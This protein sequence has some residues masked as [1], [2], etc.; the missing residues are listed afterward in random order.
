[1]DMQEDGESAMK[2]AQL[3][4]RADELRN[5][6]NRNGS[7]IPAPDVSTQCEEDPGVEGCWQKT[8]ISED[9]V[10]VSCVSIDLENESND[11]SLAADKHFEPQNDSEDSEDGATDAERTKDLEATTDDFENMV[12]GVICRSFPRSA[13]SPR[14]DARL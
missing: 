13:Y 6:L 7:R 14:C 4:E 9:D 5:L 11:S 8:N 2:L 12:E 3:R 1:M 10:D